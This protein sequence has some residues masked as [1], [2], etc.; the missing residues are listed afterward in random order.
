MSDNEITWLDE[1]MAANSDFKNKIQPERLP[2][3][4]QPGPVIITCMDPRVN[5]EAIGIPNF[6]AN[7]E[8]TS[9]VRIIRTLGAMAE[10]RSLIA[11]IFLA[12]F[13]EIV[14][15]MHSDCGCCL[16]HSKVDVI[17]ENMKN[18][19]APDAFRTFQ[20]S[21]GEPFEANLQ[22]YLKTFD[23]PY[24]AVIEEVN[25]LREMDFMPEDVIIHGLVYELSTGNVD[26]IINGY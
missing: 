10:N 23:N 11:G 14:V 1:I 13:R 3:S 4:R 7:G 21:I 9:S 22:T 16:A 18:R 20:T 24:E 5:L 15:L 19:L 6:A 2:V 26:L 12:G 17:V 25:A 8:G